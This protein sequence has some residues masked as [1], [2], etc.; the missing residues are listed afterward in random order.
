MAS[1]ETFDTII[2]HL[3][4]DEAIAARLRLERQQSAEQGRAV[5]SVAD[6]AEAMAIEASALRRPIKDVERILGSVPLGWE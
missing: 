5:N 3:P 6:A 4:V 2:P 1:I